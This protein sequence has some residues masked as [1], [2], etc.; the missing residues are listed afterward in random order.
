MLP[1]SI[2]NLIIKWYRISK[3]NEYF[4]HTEKQAKLSQRE[5]L[6]L[7]GYYKQAV[8]GACKG[9]RPGLLKIKE[10]AKY[11][12]WKACE[13]L[14]KTEAMKKYVE[15]AKERIKDLAMHVKL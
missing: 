6:K 4:T 9:A 10:R 13:N 12:A 2:K 5:L 14:T 7:Y 11:D 3:D 8:L 1:H 15:Y